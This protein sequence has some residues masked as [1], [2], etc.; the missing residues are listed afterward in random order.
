MFANSDEIESRLTCHDRQLRR[1]DGSLGLSGLQILSR[2]A[3]HGVG[4]CGRRLLRSEIAQEC[5]Q[6][7][8]LPSRLL[9]LLLVPAAM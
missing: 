8:H 7:R 4:V 3:C 6:G 2:A 5:W 9:Q 1:G